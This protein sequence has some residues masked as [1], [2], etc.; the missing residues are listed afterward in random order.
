MLKPLIEPWI[1]ELK[2]LGR[3]PMLLE[4]GAPAHSSKIANEFLQVSHIEKILWPGNSPEI[5][6]SEH[7]WPWIRRHITKGFGPSTCEASCRFQWEFEWEELPIDTINT[8]IDRILDVVRKIIQ[9]K[10]NNDFHKG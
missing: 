1:K 3:E 4:D 8:W 10:G 9:H 2:K 5:N 6:A 7:A